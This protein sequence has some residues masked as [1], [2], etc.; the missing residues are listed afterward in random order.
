MFFSLQETFF[1]YFVR[2]RACYEKRFSSEMRALSS[3]QDTE[4]HAFPATENLKNVAFLIVCLA[5]ATRTCLGLFRSQQAHVKSF[6]FL[7]ISLLFT[8]ALSS[9]CSCSARRIASA[10]TG[11]THTTQSH[12]RSVTQNI[13]VSFNSPDGSSANSLRISLLFTTASSSAYSCSARRI[14]PAHA[15]NTHTTQSHNRSGHTKY[16]GLF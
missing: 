9:A 7:K 2:F 1:F 15:G 16:C 4:T 10:H 6:C 14:A 12:N 13:V 3:P 11:N 5:S 8:A